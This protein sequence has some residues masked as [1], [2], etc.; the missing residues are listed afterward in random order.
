LVSRQIILERAS[1]KIAR[2]SLE[3]AINRPREEGGT[4]K[5]GKNKVGQKKT[6]Q[7]KRGR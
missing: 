3:E 4:V 7:R 6:K 1:R 5:K 2:K